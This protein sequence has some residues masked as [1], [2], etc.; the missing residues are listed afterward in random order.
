MIKQALVHRYD[1]IRDII[2]VKEFEC[3]EVYRNS[4]KGW[5]FDILIVIPTLPLISQP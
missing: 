2:A 3:S 4:V 5:K 1:D